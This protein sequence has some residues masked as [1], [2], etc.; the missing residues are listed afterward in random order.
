MQGFVGS[1]GMACTGPELKEGGGGNSDCAQLWKEGE[2]ETR[3]NDVGWVIW[4]ICT[5]LYMAA[6]E[7]S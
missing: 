5:V 3:M 1:K 7:Q 4:M 2:Q 6:R